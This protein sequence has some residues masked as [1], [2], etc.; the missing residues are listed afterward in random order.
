MQVG[1]ELFFVFFSSLSLFKK[2]F[3]GPLPG[4]P[5]VFLRSCKICLEKVLMGI[6]LSECLSIFCGVFLP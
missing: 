4:I 6:I 2:N 1:G 5:G 3:T